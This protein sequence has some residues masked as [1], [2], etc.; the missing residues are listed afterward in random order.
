MQH[1][2][3]SSSLL[4]VKN[5]FAPV[6]AGYD[7]NFVHVW[8][9]MTAAVWENRTGTKAQVLTRDIQSFNNRPIP[10]ITPQ[11]M[12]EQIRGVIGCQQTASQSASSSESAEAPTI[13]ERD[14]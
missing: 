7:D 12:H 4:I 10:A 13:Q 11:P 14:N 8:A 5:N 9:E 1:K 3:Y 6:R 2:S